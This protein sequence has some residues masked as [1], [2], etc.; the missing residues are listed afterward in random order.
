MLSD[1]RCM[2][3]LAEIQIVRTEIYYYNKI[4]RAHRRP[5]DNV[6]SERHILFLLAISPPSE[7]RRNVNAKERKPW[8]NI[9]I[10]DAMPTRFNSAPK[11]ACYINNVRHFCDAN[12]IHV[13]RYT[14]IEALHIRRNI[15]KCTQHLIQDTCTCRYVHGVPR[16]EPK[17]S[18]VNILCYGK[19]SK[20]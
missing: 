19:E 2:N 6:F 18:V 4:I 14:Y 10:T 13:S 12:F 17:R 7:L 11:T 16:V 1:R 9:P 15:R 5:R 3:I 8:I 20:K